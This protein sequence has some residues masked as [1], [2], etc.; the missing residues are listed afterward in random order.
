MHILGI[1]LLLLQVQL[2]AASGMVTKPGGSEPLP[3]G[4]PSYPIDPM[5]MAGVGDLETSILGESVS[6]AQANTIRSASVSSFI[7]YLLSSSLIVLI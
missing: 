7:H 5:G 2:A 6:S 4:G 3:I 1:G